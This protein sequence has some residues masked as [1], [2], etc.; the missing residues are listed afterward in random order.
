MGLTVQ[1]CQ[2]LGF[3]KEPSANLS[4]TSQEERRRVFWSTY[5]LDKQ[6]SFSR[7]IPTTLHDEECILQLPCSQDAFDKGISKKSCTLRQ[8]A[9]GDWSK[10]GVPSNSALYI[11]VASIVGRCTRFALS[12]QDD[13][14]PPW[15]TASEYSA[16]NLDLFTFESSFNLAKSLEELN[17]S[18]VIQDAAGMEAKQI[19][20]AGVLVSI[21]HCLLKNPYMLQRQLRK[22]KTFDCPTM[23]LRKAFHECREHALRL[24]DLLS[25]GR[26]MGWFAM[27]TVS[28][29]AALLSGT[30]HI[31]FLNSDDNMIQE[32]AITALEIN[33][34]CLQ[35]WS[36]YYK[37]CASIVGGSF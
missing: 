11:Y 3:Y 10:T 25:K 33:K 1:I 26:S 32:K 7:G 24:S 27:P 4:P 23:F 34:S 20:V 35:E 6:I 16:I 14:P 15:N 17:Q 28:T 12:E 30:V 19:F 21:A 2:D 29:Y 8:M 36:K 37:N 9:T 13:Q 5:L 31:I 18:S 22:S